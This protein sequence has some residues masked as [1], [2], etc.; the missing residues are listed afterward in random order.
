[1]FGLLDGDT[2]TTLLD[3]GYDGPGTSCIALALFRLGHHAALRIVFSR[4][5]SDWRR[6]GFLKSFAHSS[7]DPASSVYFGSLRYP[8]PAFASCLLYNIHSLF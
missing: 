4:A 2:W 3:E 6:N 1:M 7:E 5:D 8:G